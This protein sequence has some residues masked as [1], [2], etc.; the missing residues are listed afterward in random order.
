MSPTHTTSTEDF[1]NILNAL[2]YQV[3]FC[4]R[5][6]YIWNLFPFLSRSDS[7]MGHWSDSINSC[8][9]NGNQGQGTISFTN[10]RHSGTSSSKRHHQ[11]A[12]PDAGHPNNSSG[13]DSRSPAV[14][15][16]IQETDD[17]TTARLACPYFKKDLHAYH[18]CISYQLK[19]IKD[20]RQHIIRKHSFPDFYCGSC[21]GTYQ[22]AND[23][24]GHQSYCRSTQRNNLGPNI[25]AIT[26]YQRC[27]LTTCKNGRRSIEQQWYDIWDII[28][29]GEARPRSVYVGSYLE[30]IM[31]MLRVF[32]NDKQ[33]DIISSVVRNRDVNGLNDRDVGTVMQSVF[34]RFEQ[35]MA[36]TSPIPMAVPHSRT[37]GPNA[38]LPA[39]NR[40][41]PSTSEFIDRR[42][43]QGLDMMPTMDEPE[44]FNRAGASATHQSHRWTY[45]ATSNF[46]LGFEIPD[47]QLDE[48]LSMRNNEG[49]DWPPTWR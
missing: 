3:D 27:Q 46:G 24:E 37:R 4:A 7:S 16:K 13:G 11:A 29:P 32:W 43:L 20:V 44:A 17:S 5:S 10:P 22:T 19:R 35:E 33:S 34:D 8:V 40:P 1:A 23:F 47:D 41:R 30:E 21:N 31:P 9:V 45:P 39:M 25:N 38:L 26:G 28:F 36:S 49:Y 6:L 42:S 2:A 48:A 12:F 15:P 14:R 18:V